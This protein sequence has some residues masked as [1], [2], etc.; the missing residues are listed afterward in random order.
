MKT[1][2]YLIVGH[3]L[4]GATL[5]WQLQK[6][7]QT[8]A[9]VDREA[10]HTAS[11]VA[12]GLISPIS[13]K[14]NAASYRFEQFWAEAKELYGGLEQLTGGRF[15]YFD[16]TL[17][18]SENAGEVERLVALDA[19]Y[20]TLSAIE[21]FDAAR[22][23]VNAFLDTSRRCL[24]E[25]GVYFCCDLDLS[26]DISI[27]ESQVDVPVLDV[28]ARVIVFCQGI[29]AQSNALLSGLSFEPAK[30]EI[31][32]IASVELANANTVLGDVW[33]VPRSSDRC[34]VGATYD[35]DFENASPSEAGRQ[36]IL[37]RLGELAEINVQVTDHRAAIRPILTGRLPKIG[38]SQPHV[39]FFN[40]LGSK[41]ALRA[42]YV[43]RQLAEHL[44]L[45]QQVDEEFWLEHAIEKSNRRLIEVA[46]A[47]VLSSLEEGAVAI[48]ATVGNGFDTLFLSQSVGKTGRVF[49]VD[50][51][52]EA[53]K[54]TSARLADFEATNV[55]LMHGSHADVDELLPR[56]ITVVLPLSCSTL[57]IFLAVTK[58]LQQPQRRHLKRS[59]RALSCSALVA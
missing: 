58:Q 18:V 17:K 2:D 54:R 9:V 11:R 45:G 25:R 38:I 7:E 29:D 14:R 22:L 6:L 40:G 10:T 1:V 24:Q 43:S 31:L 28:S 15:L 36:T 48:D 57:V 19:P 53:L 52:D 33:V 23:D 32:E 35:R 13:G 41:G 50:V 37:H 47:A 12:A 5:A 56:D 44:V 30:G 55:T 42:P 59:R 20:R 21:L 27:G 49:G 4:A 51:Q 16:R 3:G 26:R 34:L 39:A 46:H 8:V